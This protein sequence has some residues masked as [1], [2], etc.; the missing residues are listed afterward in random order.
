MGAAKVLKKLLGNVIKRPAEAKYRTINLSNNK[1]KASVVSVR[2]AVEVL[3]AAGFVREAAEGQRL[4]LPGEGAPAELRAAHAQVS[5]F[6]G[7]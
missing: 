5:A 7:P 4:G 6:C 2:G 3:L 1:I